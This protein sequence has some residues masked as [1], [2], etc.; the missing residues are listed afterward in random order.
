MK[1][2]IPDSMVAIRDGLRA[3]SKRVH[4]SPKACKQKEADEATAMMHIMTRRRRA[5]AASRG[6]RAR[7]SLQQ[8]GKSRWCGKKRNAEKFH[9]P[10]PHF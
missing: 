4:T 8:A 6:G 9:P 3:V 5:A 1:S 7:P 10:P 2:N